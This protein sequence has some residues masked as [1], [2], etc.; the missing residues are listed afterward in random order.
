MSQ[1][2]NEASKTDVEILTEEFEELLR[3]QN[4]YDTKKWT[5]LE[6]NKIYIIT[7]HKTVK[8]SNGESVVI[9]LK[10]HGDV[11]GPSTLANKIKDKEPPIY[12]RPLGLK[13]C[14]S[15]KKNKYHAFDLVFPKKN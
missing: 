14:K 13:P 9:T 12:I 2:A 7:S 10:D 4:Q 11:W 8:T 5:D 15:N 1:P 6:V 3:G